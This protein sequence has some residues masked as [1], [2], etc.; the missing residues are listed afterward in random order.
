MENT[1]KRLIPGK[2]VYFGRDYNY[3]HEPKATLVDKFIKATF[4]F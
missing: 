4:W 2:N 3:L 1:L